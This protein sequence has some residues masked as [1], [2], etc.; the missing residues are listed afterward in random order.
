MG[1]GV[2]LLVYVH[3]LHIVAMVIKACSLEGGC[4]M[5]AAEDGSRGTPTEWDQGR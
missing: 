4:T 5:T 3:V 2:G 1:V